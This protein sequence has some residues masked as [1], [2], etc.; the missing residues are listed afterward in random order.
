[1]IK[2]C[3]GILAALGV[4]VSGIGVALAAFHLAGLIIGDHAVIQQKNAELMQK[5]IEIQ[6]VCRTVLDGK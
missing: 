6:G 5:I 3:A 1:M 4:L 2:D